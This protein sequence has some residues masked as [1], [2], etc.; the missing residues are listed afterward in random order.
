MIP[1]YN[2]GAYIEEAIGFALAQSYTDWE[3]GSVNKGSTDRTPKIAGKFAE[4]RIKWVQQGNSR[5]EDKSSL[6]IADLSSA[7][8]R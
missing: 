8:V 2:T 1:A 7:H 6:L 4:R 3:L 5:E